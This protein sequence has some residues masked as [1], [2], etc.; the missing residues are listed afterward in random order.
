MNSRSIFWAVLAVLFVGL[1]AHAASR[2]SSTCPVV[3][4]CESIHL[5]LMKG[6]PPLTADTLPREPLGP[7][8]ETLGLRSH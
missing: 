6:P 1:V 7:T 2:Q 5:Q 3:G 8:Q 4:S